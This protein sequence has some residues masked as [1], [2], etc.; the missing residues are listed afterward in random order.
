MAKVSITDRMESAHSA[1]DKEFR[2]LY[3]L[4]DFEVKIKALKASYGKSNKHDILSE[5]Y[6][7]FDMCDISYERGRDAE[8]YENLVKTAGIPTFDVIE[9]RMLR[10][11][12]NKFEEYPTPEE[13]MRRIVDRLSKPED[14]WEDDTLRLRILKQ[15]IKYG[16]YLDGIC[17]TEVDDKGE[18]KTVQDIGGKRYIRKYVED[19]LHKKPSDEEVLAAIDDGVFDILKGAAK[20]QKKPSGIYGLLKMADDL[21][22][23]KFRYGGSTKYA[24]YL[25][26]MVYE[27]SYYPGAGYNKDAVTDIEKNLFQDYYTNNLMRFISDVYK[28]NLSD[29]D[30]DP[31]G[32]GINYKNFAEVIYLYYIA[33]SHSILDKIRLSNE[34]IERIRRARFGKGAPVIKT[35]L[36]PS[37]HFKAQVFIDPNPEMQK[38]FSESIL[39]LPEDDFEQ[40]ILNTYNC[41]TYAGTHETTR[42]G[43]TV[44]LE[45]SRGVLELECDQETA[46][47]EYLTILQELKSSGVE[48]KECTY[49]LWFTDV[50]AFKNKSRQAIKDADPDKFAKFIELLVGINYFLG[51]SG[52]EQKTRALYIKSSSKVTRTSMIVAYYYLYNAKSIEEG[53]N[54]TRKSFEA[55]FHDF[56]SGIDEK[57]EKSGY[58]PLSS[59]SIFDIA[60]VFSSYSYINIG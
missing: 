4:K 15:F 6:Y 3:E 54:E 29:Y 60:V 12:L 57:L 50:E 16:S 31:S 38:I 34:M 55:M 1:L 2:S 58:Q 59:R 17:H 8:Y 52:D 32:Q 22:A 18:E 40:H 33:S 9:E 37:M 25:F 47:R 46:F 51:C 13:Y 27:M 49:G 5:L 30:L 39:N 53:T 45:R 26:A 36:P 56:K 24:L 14:H 19:K 48:L 44:T 11:L 7:M 20:P 21:A 35:E 10:S 28:N 41:D 43:K 23:G 42:N